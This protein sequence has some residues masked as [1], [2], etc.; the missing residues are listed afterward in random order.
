MW[1]SLIQKTASNRYPG[2]PGRGLVQ[3]MKLDAQR[4]YV[5][6]GTLALLFV[7]ICC[8]LFYASRAAALKGAM[9]ILFCFYA[10]NL[11]D[12]KETRGLA[13]DNLRPGS[14]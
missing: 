10:L 5:V 2:L 7:S 12:L 14:R 11:R 6:I 3:I 1:T 4:Q 9:S 8:E 13:K